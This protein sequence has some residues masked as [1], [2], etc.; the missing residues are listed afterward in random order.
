M[1]IPL[2][3]DRKPAKLDATGDAAYGFPMMTHEKSELDLALINP[4]S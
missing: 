4:V 3:S 2:T 1:K